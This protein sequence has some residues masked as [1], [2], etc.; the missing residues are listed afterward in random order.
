MLK[1]LARTEI[2]MR[3][4]LHPSPAA[5][6]RAEGLLR[7]LWNLSAKFRMARKKVLAVSGVQEAHGASGR[8]YPA[9]T[10]VAVRVAREDTSLIGTSLE[11]GGTRHE[12]VPGRSGLVGRLRLLQA[13][14]ADTR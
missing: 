10:A 2:I 1:V 14:G 12:K 6:V 7:A 11:R 3:P 4:L 8:E 13:K 5:T 9:S